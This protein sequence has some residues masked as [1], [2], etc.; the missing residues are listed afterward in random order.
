M[1]LMQ[2]S[3]TKYIAHLQ[4]FWGPQHPRSLETAV[5]TV[6]SAVLPPRHVLLSPGLE[7]A[8][9]L[10]MP[11]ANGRSAS[12]K[13]SLRCRACAMIR[14]S[15]AFASGRSHAWQVWGTHTSCLPDLWCDYAH[16]RIN[17][18]DLFQPLQFHGS[19]RFIV[20]RCMSAPGPDLAPSAT[21]PLNRLA[22]NAGIHPPIYT[23]S[24]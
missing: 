21:P 18:Q 15:E 13:R 9:V 19:S 6:E 1:K 3:L 17:C 22:Q 7:A 14:C 5:D 2:G 12:D 20:E 8:N 23:H 16:T 24:G 10:L 11:G 4:Y